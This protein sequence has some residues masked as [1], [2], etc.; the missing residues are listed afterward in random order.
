VCLQD[1]ANMGCG[2]VRVASMNEISIKNRVATSSGVAGH[3][4]HSDLL[5]RLQ[6]FLAVTY[7]YQSPNIS[8]FT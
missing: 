1:V 6:L 7:G 5:C 2:I 8:W 4:S 3:G